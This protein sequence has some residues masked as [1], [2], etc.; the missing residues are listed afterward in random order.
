VLA[1]VPP[2]G[3]SVPRRGGALTRLLG[4]VA[5][6]LLGWRFVGGLPDRPKFLIVGAPH[7][8]NWDFVVGMAALLALGFEASWMGKH[9]LFWWPFGRLL[10]WLGGVPVDRSRAHG[11]VDQMVDAFRTRERFVLGLTPQGTR[12]RG[13]PWKMG[14]YHIARGA[15]VPVVPVSFDYPSRTL[16]IGPP[17]ALGADLEAEVAR[18]EAFFR[19]IRGKRWSGREPEDGAPGAGG[20]EDSSGAALLG[21]TGTTKL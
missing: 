4:R 7:T 3:P 13:A 5:F 1:K 12:R 6:S 21:R 20:P 18:V 17:M 8:S 15:E 10:R 14:F 11:A 16:K 2:Y 9:T 19:G